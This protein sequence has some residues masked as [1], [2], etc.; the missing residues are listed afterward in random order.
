MDSSGTEETKLLNVNKLTSKN[1]HSWKFQVKL[2]ILGKDLCDIVSGHEVRK[3]DLTEDETAKFRK[4]EQQAL[5][6][7][8]LLVTQGQQIY[9]RNV[10]KPKAA[11][12]VL[13][14]HF[15]DKSLSTNNL[16]LA[17]FVCNVR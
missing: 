12:D 8:G 13:A 2:L 15:E 11:W 14:K 10:D 16:L 17:Q 6:Y 4:R 7:I 1:Y 5:A 9:L 3:D